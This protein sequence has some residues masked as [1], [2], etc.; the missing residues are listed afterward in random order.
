[1]PTTTPRHTSLMAIIAV[2][3][4]AAQFGA[5]PSIFFGMLNFP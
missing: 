3:A 4:T 2:P 1:M 5:E